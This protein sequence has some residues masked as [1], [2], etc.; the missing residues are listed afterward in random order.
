MERAYEKWKKTDQFVA[1]QASISLNNYP[2]PAY[3]HS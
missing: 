2:T 3:S 1:Q